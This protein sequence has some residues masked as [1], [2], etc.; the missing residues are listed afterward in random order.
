MEKLVAPLAYFLTWTTYGTRLHGDPR[1]TVGDG[2]NA[3]GTPYRPTNSA[4]MEY[5]RE[6]L[7]HEPL[8]LTQEMRDAV[9]AVIREHCSIRTWKLRAVNIRTT[10]VHVVVTAPPR[11]PPSVV[12]NQLKSWG[13]RRLRESGLVD[14][15]RTVW[16]ARGSKRQLWNEESLLAAIDYVLNRQ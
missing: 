12:E 16:T 14:P 7:L 10:H 11:V 4:L 5:E 6:R 3:P 9:E 13:T 8:T 1:G 2:Y 15:S